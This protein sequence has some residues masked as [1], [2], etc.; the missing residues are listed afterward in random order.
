M[1]S[2]NLNRQK[3]INE[4]MKEVMDDFDRFEFFFASNLKRIVIGAVVIVL[5]VAAIVVGK[6][7]INSKAKTAAEAYAKA[8]D[9]KQLEAAIT[10]YG[11]ANAAIYLRLGGM[12]LA[13]KDYAN[14][15]KNFQIAA[16]EKADTPAKWQSMITLAY[17]D[18]LEN[19]FEA[20][21]GKF[22]DL[23]KTLRAPGSSVYAA[24]AYTAAGRLYQKANKNAEA[25]Q[26]LEGG[27]SFIKGLSNEDRQA[28]AT[29][30][31]MINSLLANAPATVKTK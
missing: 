5:A 29:F 24:E 28:V 14:A 2:V 10:E 15:R 6:Y 30:E 13:K 1:S 18:E 3:K 12:Y 25:Q 22:A 17:I 31:N 11:N 23:A 27:R 26:I 20:A 19:K 16:Q 21:A 7:V 9:I 4:Q 8:A